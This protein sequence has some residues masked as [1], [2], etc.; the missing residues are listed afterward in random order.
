MLPLVENAFKYVGGDYWIRIEALMDKDELHFSVGNAV[1][2]QV[3][4]P[5]SGQ[6]SGG[7]G[8]ENLRRRLEL[9]YPE[10][11]R[12]QIEKKEGEFHAYL[13]LKG[14]ATE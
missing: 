12:L 13:I 5:I 3:S 9:L 2:G 8:L 1:P 11:H 10:R 6:K 7:I 4:I 14:L